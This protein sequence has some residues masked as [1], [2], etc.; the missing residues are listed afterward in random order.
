MNLFKETEKFITWF[1]RVVLTFFRIRPWTTTGIVAMSAASRI[2]TVLSAFLPLKV[3]LLAGSEG[4]PRYF[5]FFM[6]PENKNAWLLIL[7]AGAVALYVLTVCLDSMTGR[8]SRAAGEEILREAETIPIL[9]N[10]EDTAGNYYARFCRIL[11]DVI[12]VLAAILGGLFVNFWLFMFLPCLVLFFFSVSALFLKT[13]DRVQPA[14]IAVYIK[15]NLNNYTKTLSTVAFFS[16]FIFLLIPFIVSDYANILAAILSIII[17]RQTLAAQ[18][19]IVRNAVWLGKSRHEIN[20]LIFKNVQLVPRESPLERA[21]KELFGKEVRQKI[22]EGELAK[23]MGLEGSPAVNWLD[24]IIPGLDTFIIEVQPKASK[25]TRSLLQ[26]VFP[27]NQ[28]QKLEHELF[29][30]RHVPRAQLFAP[31]LISIFFAGPFQ[32]LICDY[33][34]GRAVSNS[35][36]ADVEFQLTERIWSCHPPAELI[37]LYSAS[38]PLLHQRLTDEFVE[39]MEIAVD[40]EEESQRLRS[41]RRDLPGIREKLHHLPLHIY[42]P[43]LSRSNVV[44]GREGGF[45][46]LNW[47]R[48]T[49]EPIGAGMP[50]FLRKRNFEPMI[51]KMRKARNDIP[52]GLCQRDVLLAAHCF[53]L[54]NLINRKRYKAAF[55]LVNA[56]QTL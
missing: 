17:I 56:I 18:T 14:K 39:R 37:R 53:D 24:P 21:H 32:C 5:Q 29:L 50:H 52:A 2:T 19:L 49:L 28:Q 40:R 9:N 20:A 33:G 41:F 36:W 12:F 8:L 43:D 25:E 6:T 3:V 27:P 48:W 42:N 38:A 13:A 51:G 15:E 47:C 31:D 22:A 35:D 4:V 54:E 34:A 7:A 16:G 44:Y 45:L 11:A 1:Y 26:Q 55:R 30:F 46:V 10:Q 23:V